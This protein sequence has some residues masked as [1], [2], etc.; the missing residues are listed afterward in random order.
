ML[1][2]SVR[3]GVISASLLV[4]LAGCSQTDVESLM[5]D[6]DTYRRNGEIKAAIIQ[7]K[8]ALKENPNSPQARLGLAQTFLD[9]GD[10]PSAEQ[11]FRKAR[12]LGMTG[13][14]IQFGLAR[15]LL[16]QNAADKALVELAA[17]APTNPSETATGH[18]LRGRAKVLL[19]DMEAARIEYSRALDAS[20]QN[21]D[22]LLGLASLELMLGK[23]PEARALA[24]AALSA[25]PE[26]SDAWIVKGDIAVA[27]GQLPQ[28]A[29]AY[30]AA[31]KKDPN[32]VT[33]KY[34]LALLDINKNQLDAA[35]NRLD[36]LKKALPENALLYYQEA[37]IAYKRG[38]YERAAE[39]SLRA[40][41]I[42]PEHTSSFLVNGLA[43][44][45]LGN[46]Q[47]AEQT[48][49]HVLAE[50]PD[51][52]YARKV[53]VAALIRLRDR[54][55]ALKVLSRALQDA[56]NDPQVLALAS[57]VE[58]L[59]GRH[60]KAQEMMQA[61]IGIDPSNTSL[62][63]ELGL[64]Q[65]VAG[66]PVSA[67]AILNEAIERDPN[68][69]SATQALLAV[70][71]QERKFDAALGTLKKLEARRPRDPAI[72][73]LR[74]SALVG[75]GQLGPARASFEK[76][77]E[78]DPNHVPALVQLSEL[79]IK[80]GNAPRARKRFEDL[81]QRDQDN[82]AAYAALAQ[83]E[84]A[85]GNTQGAISLL[86]RARSRAPR[87]V[88]VRMR[89]ARLYLQSRQ[90]LRAIPVAAEANK[91]DPKNPEVLDLLG[92]AQLSAGHTDNASLTFSILARD[93]PESPLAHYRLAMTRVAQG[94]N[95]AAIRE[96]RR[97]IELKPKFIDAQAGLAAA[98]LRQGQVADALAVAR[99]VREQNPKD[100]LGYVL[101]ADTLTQAGRHAEAIESYRRALAMAPN[102]LVAGRLFKARWKGGDV[103]G[104]TAEMRAWLAAHPRDVA[105]RLLLA[106]SATKKGLFDLGVEQYQEALKVDPNNLVAL[107]N[108]ATL[109]LRTGHPDSLA[110]AERAR[111]LAPDNGYVLDTYGWILLHKKQLK[112]ALESLQAAVKALPDAPDIR[113]HYGVALAQAGNK[114]Q[115][116]K[117]IELALERNPN[118]DGATQARDF[119]QT[120]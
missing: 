28:A 87:S 115:A 74:G 104:A 64:M 18:S 109:Y 23:W 63:T 62:R 41:R 42:M 70:Q 27:E 84:V 119:L 86:E 9:A 32:N 37:L 105:N 40:M 88:P 38:Q 55:R 77:L 81:L 67:T 75:K 98:H 116:R 112:P 50:E 108:L 94:D 3:T 11:E 117:E 51:N 71:L 68:T 34:K 24:D 66:D 44:F 76:A 5:R 100:P 19:G 73:T 57:R 99:T 43:Q 6:A 80:D 22:A 61:A 92:T 29:S 53:A 97:A 102:P 101:E 48:L 45:Q 16:L 52:L 83:F 15:A 58:V 25:A 26:R 7:Y 17:I 33:A 95:G 10:G 36:E 82:I 96:F 54:D 46:F 91:L 90:P 49:A 113:Y 8:N 31:L 30:E 118:F 107:N 47:Q 89:L 59:F 106:D 2:S 35:Q 79:D 12:A 39:A 56:P 93:Y 110:L 4:A 14:D 20:R 103:A 85:S 60:K 1:M 69:I 72:H 13:A 120:L 114:S 21:A 65:I 78:L 111:R